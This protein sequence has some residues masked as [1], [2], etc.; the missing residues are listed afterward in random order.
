MTTVASFGVIGESFATIG[1]AAQAQKNSR[2]IGLNFGRIVEK[3]GRTEGSSTETDM[4]GGGGI[5]GGGDISR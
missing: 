5:T 1:A 2:A 4:A 3:F